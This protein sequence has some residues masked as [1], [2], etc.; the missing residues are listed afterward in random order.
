MFF[1]HSKYLRQ[2][3][4]KMIEKVEI[5]ILIQQYEVLQLMSKL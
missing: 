2:K 1:S 5:K 4:Y 3:L